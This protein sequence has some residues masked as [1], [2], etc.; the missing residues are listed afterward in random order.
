MTS[1]SADSHQDRDS[2]EPHRPSSSG[3]RHARVAIDVAL[4]L[5]SEHNFYTGFLENASISGIFVAT[6]TPGRIGD[7]VEFKIQL[8]DTEE[9]I[10]GVGRV[11]WLRQ[12]SETSDTPPGMGLEFMELPPS[13]RRRIDEFLW[14][15]TPLFFDDADA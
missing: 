11:R 13:S 3:R 4:T 15:R 6:H 8:G 5:E 10:V 7:R 2:I 1:N 14:S 12:Y 9:P